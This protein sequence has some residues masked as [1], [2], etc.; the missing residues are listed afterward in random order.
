MILTPGCKSLDYPERL[1]NEKLGKL[2]FSKM[3]FKILEVKAMLYLGHKKEQ[4]KLFTKF[5]QIFRFFLA[6][7]VQ[8]SEINVSE[9]LWGSKMTKI[10]F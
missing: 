6:L 10:T 7:H 5:F 1:N 9:D 2:S 4:N 3:T 8:M